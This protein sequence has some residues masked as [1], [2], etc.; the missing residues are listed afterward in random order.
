[1]AISATPSAR[2]VRRWRY[3]LSVARHEPTFLIGLLLTAVLLYLI[4]APLVAV[5]SDAG[6]VQ[7]GDESKTGQRAGE[8]TCDRKTR[9]R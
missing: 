3:R 5:L 8:L 6:R 4:V 9:H 1:M 2:H 7:F